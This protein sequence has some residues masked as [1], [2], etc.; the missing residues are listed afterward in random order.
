[1]KVHSA[2]LSDKG[3]VRGNNEDAFLIDE[4]SSLFVVADGVGG[5]V[6]GEIASRLAIEIISNYIYKASASDCGRCLVEAMSAANEAVNEAGRLNSD[7]KGMASTAVVAIY[8]EDRLIIANVGDSRAYLLRNNTIEQI[9]EDHSLVAEQLRKG[10]ISREYAKTADNKNV[11]TRA[12]G[13]QAEVNT[14]IW[15]INIISGDSILL[16]TDGLTDAVEDEQILDLT[17]G[18]QPEDAVKKL[19]D[20]ANSKGGKDNTTALIIS[21]S[22]GA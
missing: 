21:F 1:M 17:M 14:D 3:L 2:A 7:L 12:I 4:A 6:A 16:C 20:E 13:A 9:T 15:E 18:V 19:V 5:N 11:I 8:E 22:P 10:V